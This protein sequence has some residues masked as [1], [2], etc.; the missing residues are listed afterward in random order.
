MSNSADKKKIMVVGGGF[1]GMTASLLLAEQGHAV[2]LV[3]KEAAIGGFFPLLDNTFPT[4]SCGVCFLSPRQP[5]Y[6]PFVECRLHQNLEIQVNARPLAIA[7]EQ[8]DF[9]VTLA[10]D[11]HGVDQDKCIDCGK[12][13]D[14]CPV[15][16]ADEFSGGLEERKAIYKQ[17]P[18]MVKAGYRIDAAACNRCGACVD[19]CPTK[20][21][22]LDMPTGQR[23]EQVAA[24]LLTPGFSLVEGTLKGEFGFGR[25]ANVITSRQMERMISYSGPTGGAPRLL[26]DGS[27]P[28][29]VA[30][31]QCAGSRDIACGRGYCS[32]V[33]CM[34]AT[35]QAMFLKKR[36]PETEVTIY[37][38]D[39]RGMGKEYE[40]YLWEAEEHYGIRYQ[41][42][43]ISTVKEDPQSRK[44]RLI[45]DDHG[46]RRE[47]EF[48][49][50]VLS[51][52]F[53]APILD[54]T[55][56]PADA[57]DDYGFCRPDEFFPAATS[58]AGIYAAGAFTGP[59]DI[60]ETVM[61]AACAADL[62]A[63]A[64][65]REPAAEQCPKMP[66][67]GAVWEERPRIGVFLCRCSGLLEEQLDLESLAA[68]VRTEPHVAHVEII[69]NA[70][71][72]GGFAIVQ[73]AIG[74]HSLNRMVLGACSVREMER[75]CDEFAR[76][77]GFNSA[78]FALA[79]LREQC[80]LVHDNNRQAAT[81]K[82]R[83]LLQAAITQVFGSRQTMAVQTIAVDQR[84]LVIGGGVAG[85]TAA[86]SLAGRGYPVTLLEKEEQLG[87]RL[88]KDSHYTL[89][90]G[91]PKQLVEKLRQAVAAQ[92]NLDVYC[93]ATVSHHEG[94]TGNYTTIFRLDDDQ[95]DHLIRHG[96][97]VMATGGRE[98]STDEY[99]RGQDERVLTQSEL[100]SLVA[101]NG[102]ALKNLQRVVMIQCVG[103]RERGKREY[104]SRVCCTHALKNSLKL[105]ELN[106]T[107]EVVVLYRDLRAYGLYEDDY[108]RAREAGVLFT[109]YDVEQKPVVEIGS[110]S[111]QVTY[112]DQILQQKLSL[113]ADYVVLSTG[114]E[115]HEVG[116]LSRLL[117]LPLDD[118]GFYQEANAKAAL[119]DFV[120]EG[121][122]HCGLASA[123]LHINETLIRA[124]A[125]A[126]RA[127][128]VLGK[129]ELVSEKTAVTVSTRLC[130]GCG[131][132][133]EACPYGA[134]ELNQETRIA[135]VHYDLCHG[136]GSCASVC[137][138]GAT[139][140]YGFDKGQVMAMVNRL[141]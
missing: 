91:E 15:A 9:I 73:Q 79:N 112:D 114:V 35:K 7:G 26:T 63:A 59:K 104:C 116:E 23:D 121:R 115:P 75:Q 28:E 107:L 139:Q 45:A 140:Q 122:Y 137:P 4:N 120:G 134:R 117:G 30:F 111:L 34:Y 84:A 58:V 17:Y 85:M 39:L 72:T 61:E 138:N 133:V 78:F 129:G 50:V 82:A 136:C 21:I 42:S 113:A 49:L 48:D 13:S 52:G 3:E 10:V 123:P 60:P 131:L 97:L 33:C 68:A 11:P 24:I 69:D 65:S 90:G 100:E 62:I 88:A 31:I 110:H 101:T 94:R 41:R 8:G 66:R 2:C 64:V 14:V 98:A 125:A 105:K 22:D 37:Y 127:A 130:S 18:K 44:L 119:V 108:R 46:R 106:P 53:D 96:V 36:L 86:L 128:T 1:A 77:A 92:E 70:C 54:C 6:C 67:E 135:D 87:G 25:Y 12:C 93:R 19:I 95:T 51:L 109:T 141:F 74:K 32:S 76:L 5:A 43:M 55:G 20:A 81:A 124:R 57:L 99:L 132:C 102:E 38:M 29:R 40:R 126:A 89:R 47:E 56:L 83:A 103:S 80:S 118:F 27:A 71:I 16:V